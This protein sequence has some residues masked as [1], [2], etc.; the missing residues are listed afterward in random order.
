MQFH[1]N[2]A[3][4]T[5]IKTSASE[6]LSG[7]RLND[8]LRHLGGQASGNSREILR[9]EAAISIACAQAVMKKR[10][11]A[12]TLHSHRKNRGARGKTYVLQSWRRRPAPT[13]GRRGVVHQGRRDEVDL[14]AD[15]EE[16]RRAIASTSNYD[17]GSLSRL[18]AEAK[19][20]AKPRRP[21]Q[22]AAK[23]G[24]VAARV[25]AAA[26][27]KPGSPSTSISSPKQRVA[28][29]SPSKPSS[30]AVAAAVKSPLSPAVVDKGKQKAADKPADDDA[31][32]GAVWEVPCESW[33][34]SIVAATKVKAEEDRH[35]IYAGDTNIGHLGFPIYT[36]IA[37]RTRV[38]DELPEAV[39]EEMRGQSPLAYFMHEFLG[40]GERARFQAAMRRRRTV[41]V[42]AELSH[43]Q[44]FFFRQLAI[45]GT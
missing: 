16:E 19:A 38:P 8:G 36:D 25:V 7:Y 1:L 2:N 42:P 45:E 34:A 33:G 4:S 6:L 35:D 15:D 41:C 24:P 23:L 18:L 31:L 10:L 11:S 32:L 43:P 30:S 12:S 40:E 14:T 39:K 9:D 5:V 26:Q 21:S 29:A 13:A 28:V 3:Y 37:F 22:S 44:G 20:D 27:S 17:T